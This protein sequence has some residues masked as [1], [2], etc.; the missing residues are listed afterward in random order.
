M[1]GVDQF[2]DFRERPWRRLSRTIGYVLINTYGTTVEADEAAARV[3]RL[4]RSVR[5][6]DPVTAKPYSADD[7]DL[8]EWIH[9]VEVDSYLE[10]YLAYGAGLSP[11]D[12]IATWPKRVRSVELLG[13]PAGRDPSTVA[14]LKHYLTSVEG[15]LVLSDSA[16]GVRSLVLRTPV[17]FPLNT[18]LRLPGAARP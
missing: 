5:G 11:V 18:P 17:P 1:A 7:H 3:R 9:A 13:L 14:E 12:A 15:D 8:L 10:A 16:R 4:H 2:S 6:I